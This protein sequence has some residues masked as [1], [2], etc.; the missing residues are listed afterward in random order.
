M[1][2]TGV[3]H[4]PIGVRDMEKSL[5]FWRDFMGLQITGD[6]GEAFPERR[7]V[8]LRWNPEKSQDSVFMSLSAARGADA[9]DSSTGLGQLGVNHIAFW[10]DDLEA[11]AKRAKAMGIEA[12]MEPM[13]YGRRYADHEHG[14]NFRSAMFLDPDGVA[15]QLEEWRE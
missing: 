15:V 7:S 14:E 8:F 12:R 5:V 13:T 11:Y 3:S 1:Q 6:T 9:R 2:V 10:V 4:I